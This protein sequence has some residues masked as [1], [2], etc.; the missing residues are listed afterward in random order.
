[1]MRGDARMWHGGSMIDN[2]SDIF[3]I[4]YGMKAINQ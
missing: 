2:V 3:L 1:M 4:V